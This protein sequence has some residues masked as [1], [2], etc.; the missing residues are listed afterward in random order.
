MDD[1]RMQLGSPGRFTKDRRVVAFL[2]KDEFNV[3]ADWRPSGPGGMYILDVKVD[4][5]WYVQEPMGNISEARS[6]IT[7]LTRQPATQQVITHVPPTADIS[8][9]SSTLLTFP[10][11]TATSIQGATENTM[12][13]NTSLVTATPTGMVISIAFA[14]IVRII[15]CVIIVTI[16]SRS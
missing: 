5:L 4:Q 3:G 13:S 16:L 10:A 2:Q 1:C 14:G 15:L 6:Q 7:A 12:P 11:V 9:T 8:P